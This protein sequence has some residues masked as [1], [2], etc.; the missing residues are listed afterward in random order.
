LLRRVVT[1]ATSE[2][3]NFLVGSDLALD[4]LCSYLLVLISM[5]NRKG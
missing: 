2:A 1:K 5:S 4:D 3:D